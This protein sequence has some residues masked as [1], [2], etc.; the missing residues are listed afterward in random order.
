MDQ[1][2]TLL[3]AIADPERGEIDARRVVIVTPH[4]DDETLGFGVV[5]RRLK[6]VRLVLAT[7]GSPRDGFM[8]RLL[9][10]GTVE[11]YR[12]ARHHE[13]LAA[14]ALAGL[15]PDALTRLEIP[16]KEGAWNV[17]RIAEA[18]RRFFAEHE[19]EA[20]LTNAYEGGHPDHDAV[21]AAVALATRGT[22]IEVIEGPL[23]RQSDGRFAVQ[24]FVPVEGIPIVE[25]RL[26][27]E[28]AAHK[29]A[30]LACYRTQAAIFAGY[31]PRVERFRHAPAY[32]FT[33]PP[34]GGAINYEVEFFPWRTWA[35]AVKPALEAA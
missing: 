29:L 7:D 17:G 22:G 27:P 16:D 30:M 4:P 33:Q 11:A 28:E 34:N 31:E 25:T 2:R 12:D 13:L 10:L 5:M 32:D 3:D 21:A 35:E 14:I 15:P 18:L 19:T 1:G 20:V 23:Y 8:A 26:T 6:G 24:T 9:G